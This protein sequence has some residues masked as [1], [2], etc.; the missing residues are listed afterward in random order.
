MGI[1]R[2]RM[3][4]R[5]CKENFEFSNP[6]NTSYQSPSVHY[7]ANNI[8]FI[9]IIHGS[10]DGGRTWCVGMRLALNCPDS[11]ST[12]I[13]SSLNRDCTISIAF[14]QEPIRTGKLR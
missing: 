9:D 6:Q 11:R 4:M 3:H 2:I 12:A 7:M 1:D 14:G 5:R 10:D 13:D 8:C